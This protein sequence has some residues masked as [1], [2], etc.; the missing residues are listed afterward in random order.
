MAGFQ[1]VPNVVSVKMIHQV[2]GQN[3]LN[4]FHFLKATPATLADCQQIATAVRDTYWKAK[5]QQIVTADVFMESIMATA[6]DSQAAPQFQLFMVPGE[7]NGVL[8]GMAVPT[9]STLVGSYDTAERSRNGR[10][11]TY[12]SGMP[13]QQLAD[14]TEV[15]NTYLTSF[16]EALSA[17]LTVATAVSGT[18]VVVSRVLAGIQRPTGVPIPVT[19]ITADR[20]LDSQR[21][22]LFGRGT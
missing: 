3:C 9:G 11:R 10:G 22:R 8:G 17:L 13:A 2:A 18:L 19:A 7:Q 20:Y 16:I 5:M 4:T 1:A 12:V 6:L 21:R 15:I 14:P